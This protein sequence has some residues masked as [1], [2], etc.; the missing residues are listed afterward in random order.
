M[1]T[2]VSYWTTARRSARTWTRR[3]SGVSL[4]NRRL[5]MEPKY[6]DIKV[7]LTDSD[8]NAFAILGRCCQTA[9]RAGLPQE[10]LE[11]FREEAIAGDYDQLLQTCMRWFDIC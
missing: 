6:P 4:T 7:T 5:P 10:E 9:R 2:K 1:P 11:A 3:S 8:G